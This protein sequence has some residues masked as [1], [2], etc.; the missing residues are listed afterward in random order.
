[1]LKP[2][3]SGQ[4]GV[5]N[6]SRSIVNQTDSSDKEIPVQLEMLELEAAEFKLNTLH[7]TQTESARNLIHYLA[8]G[9][10]D[11]R[12]IQEKLSLQGLWMRCSWM[13]P[14]S[15]EAPRHVPSF[16]SSFG[17]QLEPAVD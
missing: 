12:H 3:L 7:H 2:D 6:L 9:R 5:D 11:R 15:I 1:L 8:L 10:H 16:L 13:A 14:I 4:E 17:S